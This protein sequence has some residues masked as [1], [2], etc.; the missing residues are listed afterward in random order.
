MIRKLFKQLHIWLSI[1]LGVVMS[2]TC[3]T[4]AVLIFEGEITRSIYRDVYYVDDVR[5]APLSIDEIIAAV[6]PALIEGQR[7]MSI[8]TFDDAER[9]YEVALSAPD[10]KTLLVD[11]YSGEIRGETQKIE[12]F[13][14][15]FRL[16]RWLMDSRPTDG[17]VFWGKLIV[18]ISTLMMALVILTGIV[19]WWPKSLK[20]WL[21]RS[22]MALRL[23]WHR[24]WYDMHVVGGIYATLLL[25]VMALTGLTWSFT[26]Y[27]KGFYALF[28][29]EAS[30]GGKH[31]SKGM[32]R[33]KGDT[34]TD[35][36]HWQDVYDRLAAANPDAPK[37]TISDGTASVA[38]VGVINKRATD[39]YT[40]DTTTGE[41]TSEDLY[42]ARTKSRKM[43]GVI[44]SLHVGNFGGMFTRVLWFLAAM[45][46]ATLPLTGYYLWIKR[47]FFCK[48]KK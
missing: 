48:N 32:V 1:P 24:F 39:S 47:K 10:S 2:I 17:G 22:K 19:I 14:T 16:H 38:P 3:F 15:M 33:E 12:L 34:V 6:E 30:Q 13:R 26:W 21:S 27:N 20:M 40:F 44:Y 43:R 23:G 31:G 42:R 18:G 11:Q 9:S 36:Q 8:T 5:S 29:A 35:Y 4:G 7:I 41:I 46:G 25:L 45:L 28:G 37:I